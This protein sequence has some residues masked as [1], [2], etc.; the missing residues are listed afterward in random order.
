MF[1]ETMSLRQEAHLH[2][3]K[4]SAS[5]DTLINGRRLRHRMQ[6]KVMAE[7]IRVNIRRVLS[8]ATHISLALDE[9]QYLKIVRFRAD[10]PS[11]QRDCAS[12]GGRLGA[13]GFSVSGILGMLDCSKK[14]AA[15]FE[16]DHAVTAVKQ[17]DSF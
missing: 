4:H 5:G 17:L 3:K 1:S 16:A 6:L 10:V 13:S 8:E 2:D 9:A 12:S 15:D 7:V 14:H 11:Q